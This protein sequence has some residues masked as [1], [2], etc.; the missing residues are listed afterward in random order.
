[1]KFHRNITDQ[2]FVKAMGGANWLEYSGAKGIT[3][4]FEGIFSIG[5]TF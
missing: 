5:W 2:V 3:T 1:M 4:Q